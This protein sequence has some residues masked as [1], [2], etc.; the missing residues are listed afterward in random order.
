M[1]SELLQV[2]TTADNENALIELARSAIQARLAASAQ[3][4]GPVKSLFWHLDKYGEGAEWIV[5]FR[6]TVD[7]YAHLESHI[8]ADHPWK[9]PEIV[10]VPIVAGSSE[11]LAWVRRT[12]ET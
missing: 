12:V 8:L 1:D 2:S 3:V 6:T 5:L 7:R 4:T 9:N 11:Y 10:A